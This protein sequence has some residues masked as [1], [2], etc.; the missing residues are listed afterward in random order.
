MKVILLETIERLG[1]TGEIISVKDGYARNYL[2]PKNKAKPV[3]PGNMKILD[4]LKKKE[5]LEE[6]KKMEKAMAIA[7]KINNLSLTI[8]AHAGEEEKLFGSV[9]NDDISNALLEE[10]IYIDKKDVI[11]D[12]PIKKLGV[13]QV[14]VKVHPEVKANLRVWVVKK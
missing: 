9:S 11:L 13:Y 7:D 3:T 6:E 10:G 4:A 1:K 14:M 12:E 8:S 5:I 2:I